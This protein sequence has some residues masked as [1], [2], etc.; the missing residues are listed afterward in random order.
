MKKLL[1]VEVLNRTVI[2]REASVQELS[3]GGPLVIPGNTIAAGSPAG[4]CQVLKKSLERHIA[5]HES[6]KED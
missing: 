2:F 5:E 4:A 1:E 6:G 3:G